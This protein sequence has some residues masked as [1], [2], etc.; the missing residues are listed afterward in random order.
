M[1]TCVLTWLAFCIGLHMQTS[2]GLCTGWPQRVTQGSGGHI[3]VEVG[4]GDPLWVTL[5]W[6]W[7][8]VTL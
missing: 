8:W 3:E 5:E 7:V 1:N 2:P 4:V 6:K